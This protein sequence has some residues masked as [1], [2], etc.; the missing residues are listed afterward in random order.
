MPCDHLVPR[1]QFNAT[2]AITIAAP[3]EEVWPWI[4]QVGYGRAGFYTYNLVEN[5]GVRSADEAVDGLQ[6]L[7]IGD[8]IPMFHESHGLAIAYKVQSLA[9]DEC[10]LWVHRPR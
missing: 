4:V 8:L 1:A 6:Q 3:P 7:E 5:A 2:R 10:M 9:K